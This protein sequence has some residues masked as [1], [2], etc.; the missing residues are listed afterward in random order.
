MAIIRTSRAENSRKTRTASSDE[1]STQQHYSKLP[2][3]SALI[4][5]GS[6]VVT[7]RSTVHPAE[8][9]LFHSRRTASCELRTRVSPTLYR[10]PVFPIT[11]GVEAARLA[12]RRRNT[13]L[14]AAK[15]C[16]GPSGGQSSG[17]ILAKY[18]AEVCIPSECT[19]AQNSAQ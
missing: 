11:S 15:Y 1:K 2:I 10:R 14:L 18:L 17:G 19:N 16:L 4:K 12:A 7:V 13:A 3:T 9:E 5:K 8:Q 6:E